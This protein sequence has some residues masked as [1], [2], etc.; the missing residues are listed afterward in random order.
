MDNEKKVVNTKKVVVTKKIEEN[1][2]DKFIEEEKISQSLDEHLKENIENKEKKKINW[3]NVLTY[4]I[5][6][7]IVLACLF[8]IYI[9][10]DK[11]GMNPFEEK[12][13]TTTTVDIKYISTS[14]TTTSEVRYIEP[15][16]TT[17]QTVRT[18]YGGEN[19]GTNNSGNSPTTG[20]HRVTTSSNAP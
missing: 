1:E 18:V 16:T 8:L 12:T 5:M 6:V 2:L 3:M 20:W 19:K 7:V 14:T 4:F 17:Q 10:L 13:T 11:N 15:T 9:F